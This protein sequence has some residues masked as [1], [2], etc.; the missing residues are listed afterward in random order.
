MDERVPKK[1]VG[2]GRVC[3]AA[4]EPVAPDPTSSVRQA[5]QPSGA[6]VY[7]DAD[8]RVGVL[9]LRIRIYTFEQPPPGLSTARLAVV[10]E[11][12][13]DGCGMPPT[14]RAGA[15]K[16]SDLTVTRPHAGM[17]SRLFALIRAAVRTAREL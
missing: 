15:A 8:S 16:I 14:R 11:S 13:W 5:W 3:R 2:V 17:S 10:P 7:S 4:G 9:R 12:Y 1:P 6:S